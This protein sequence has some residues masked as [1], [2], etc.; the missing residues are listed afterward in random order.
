MDWQQMI[1]IVLPMITGIYLLVIAYYLYLEIFALI[2]ILQSLI[3]RGRQTHGKGSR[4]DANHVSKKQT[5]GHLFETSLFFNH[6]LA[7]LS[8]WAAIAII[9]ELPINSGYKLGIVP[10]A[11][12]VLPYIWS[13]TR[14][15]NVG[16]NGGILGVILGLLWLAWRD[17]NISLLHDSFYF[18]VINITA[19]MSGWLGGVVGAGQIKEGRQVNLFKILITGQGAGLNQL[20]N[21]V[22]EAVVSALDPGADRSDNKTLKFI[23][24]KPQM[25]VAQGVPCCAVLSYRHEL[26]WLVKVKPQKI[27]RSWLGKREYHSPNQIID[28]VFNMFQN[29]VTKAIFLRFPE[30]V[31]KQQSPINTPNQPVLIYLTVLQY[32]ET[33]SIMWV[34]PEVEALS[35]KT[36][37]QITAALSQPIGQDTQSRPPWSVQYHQSVMM[38]NW[39]PKIRLE[40]YSKNTYGSSMPYEAV[41]EAQLSDGISL[42]KPIMDEIAANLSFFDR[43]RGKMATFLAFLVFEA[44]IAFLINMVSSYAYGLFRS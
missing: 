19:N 32:R 42:P 8:T 31:E 22:Q 20:V 9:A 2:L 29:I 26:E 17:A 15:T 36:S 12:T 6:S 40:Q 14:A 10:V 24:S 5:L 27:V 43:F 38:Q 23:D 1:P 44:A 4:N 33:P 30:D 25:T 7:I 3:I 35:E 16:I 34:N 28:C 39:K 18:L 11:A 41:S 21:K 13:F 37:Q